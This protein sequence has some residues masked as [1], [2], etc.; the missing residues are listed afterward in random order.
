MLVALDKDNNRIYADANIKYTECFCPVCGEQ[1]THKKGKIK[2]PHFAH[3]TETN[4]KWG[5]DKDSKSEWHI[6]M[7][8]YFPRE[9][10]EVRFKDENTGEIHIADVFIPE[11]NIVIEFQHSP[12]SS[13]EF[14]SRSVFHINN[15]RRIAWIFDE[16]KENCKEN[17][18]GK[19]KP[20]DISFSNC[21]KFLYSD[22]KYKWSHIHRSSLLSEALNSNFYQFCSVLIY[23]GVE[24]DIVH[25][26]IAQ[27]CN[28]KFVLFSFHKIELSTKLNS[29]D[30]FKYDDYWC[31]QEPYKNIIENYNKRIKEQNRQ[32]EEYRRE[33]AYQKLRAH[34]SS[35]KRYRRF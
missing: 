12:I 9:N 25:K 29:D 4:C 30:L 31:Q 11:T 27:E 23:T 33:L 1:L 15:G 19:F 21:D 16:S 28:F 18:L 7:Q 6:R 14:Y 5:K 13:E 22:K 24:G 35:R 2:A 32:L 10:Q 8:N 34:T 3:K 17:E 20:D 26:I